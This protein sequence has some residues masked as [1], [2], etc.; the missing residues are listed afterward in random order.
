MH[1]PSLLSKSSKAK[2]SDPT[3]T[4]SSTHASS[5]TSTTTT[6]M[7]SLAGK[8]ALITG[9]SK[10]IGRATALQLASQG[11]KVV[12]NYSSS[13]KDAEDVVAQIGSDNAIAIKADVSSVPELE[14]LVNKTVQK[15]GKIDILIPNAGIL[16]N[17]DLENTTEADFDKCFGVNVK[18]VY[19]LVQVC[20]SILH[21]RL[22]ELHLLTTG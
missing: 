11:A 1:L 12:I 15:F 22:K 3:S 7:A 16:P 14:G 5:S 9:S 6:N 19:F 13:S 4:S 10:G 2:H 21:P 17:K 18:G 20:V 8:V